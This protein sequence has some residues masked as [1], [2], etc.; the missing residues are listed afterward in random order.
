MLSGGGAGAMAE[1]C[2]LCAEGN[3]Y[4]RCLCVVP[5]VYTV[6]SCEYRI[7]G[8]TEQQQRVDAGL[9]YC[10]QMQQVYKGS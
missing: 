4:L 9:A 2:Y 8:F 5:A 3:V 10:A 1:G 7:R 6:L